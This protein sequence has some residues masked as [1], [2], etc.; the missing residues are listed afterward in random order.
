MEVLKSID[1]LTEDSNVTDDDFLVWFD[2]S[3]K[4]HKKVKK[5]N[6]GSSKWTSGTGDDIYRLL[7]N[8]GVGVNPASK[9]HVRLNSDQWD[10]IVRPATV[11]GSP[12]SGSTEIALGKTGT[13]SWL[14]IANNTAAGAFPVIQTNTGSFAFFFNDSSDNSLLL[15]ATRVT[16]QGGFYGS[17]SSDQRLILN[18]GTGRYRF[19]RNNAGGAPFEID[20]SVAN[21][22]DLSIRDLP[23]SDPLIANRVW[24]NGGVLTLSAG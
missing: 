11:Q 19:E 5:L 6:F 3:E 22:L 12:I 9:F 8:V 10:F 24:N 2:E 14:R 1:V 18:A 16:L 15:Q 7:G 13:S 17:N 21:N 4:T 20:A 23:T